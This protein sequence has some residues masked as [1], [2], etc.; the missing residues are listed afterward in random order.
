MTVSGA[1][2]SL[3]CVPRTQIGL[4]FNVLLAPMIFF[5]CAYY[6]WATL[7]V[8]PWFQRAVLLN[9]LVYASEGFRLALD[10]GNAPHVALAGLWR[11]GGFSL[12]FTWLGLRKFQKRAVD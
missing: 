7:H 12:L 6:P 11:A 9:P 3:C 4:V 1:D 8:I 10:S 2:F 5:G